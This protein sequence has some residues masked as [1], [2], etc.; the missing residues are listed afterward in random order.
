MSCWFD[1]W[2]NIRMRIVRNMVQRCVHWIREKWSQEC[3]D[4]L[5]LGCCQSNGAVLVR[6]KSCRCFHNAI[7]VP[8]LQDSWIPSKVERRLHE[9]LDRVL[10]A[11]PQITPKC[12]RLR[13]SLPSTTWRSG[14]NRIEHDMAS[15]ESRMYQADI[16][17]I[18]ASVGVSNAD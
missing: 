18:V 13:R 10:P 8:P 7:L 4:L 12:T 2:I 1:L 9:S 14:N 16:C 3:E 5:M 15:E 17:Q 6:V 11:R